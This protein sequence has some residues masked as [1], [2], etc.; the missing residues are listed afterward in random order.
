MVYTGDL[1]AHDPDN[2]LS[3]AYIEYSEV[4]KAVL[5]RTA[6]FFFTKLILPEYLDCRL[7]YTTSFAACLDPALST[8]H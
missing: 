4:R 6:A 5:R 2:Q 8:L 3:R 1:V 7:Y